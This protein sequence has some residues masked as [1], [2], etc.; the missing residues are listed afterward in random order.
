MRDQKIIKT[1]LC[2]SSYARSGWRRLDR[3]GDMKGFDPLTYLELRNC[4]W[5]GST[6]AI[7]RTR[8]LPVLALAI[9]LGVMVGAAVASLP[10]LGV[11]H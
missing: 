5:C 9:G 10:L 7:K 11:L 3:V 2:G 4:H 1:C 6:I 8:I